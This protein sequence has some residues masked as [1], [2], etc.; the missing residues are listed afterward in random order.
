[1]KALD[2]APSISVPVLAIENSADDA[3][4]QPHTRQFFD[5]VGSTD[6]SFALIKGANHYYAGQ[7]DQLAQVVALTLGWLR[8]RNLA[9]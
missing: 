8:E 5:A 2:N 1:M 4:P 7:P 6:K 3:V 9:S